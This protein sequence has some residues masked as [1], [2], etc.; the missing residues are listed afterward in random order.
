VIQLTEKESVVTDEEGKEL[1][2]VDQHVEVVDQRHAVEE[3]VGGGNL[4]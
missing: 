4:Q 1:R 3:L 2:S